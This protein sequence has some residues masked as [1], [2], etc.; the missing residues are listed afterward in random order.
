M[1]MKC[2]N[3][4]DSV[5]IATMIVSPPASSMPSLRNITLADIHKHFASGKL[6]SSQLV[7]AYLS[8]IAEVDHEFNSIIETNPDANDIARALDVE[9]A[10]GHRRSHLHGIP[11]LLK[12]NIPTLDK[13]ETTCGSLALV[14]ARPKQE[15]AVVAAL[16]NAGAVMLGKSNMAEWVGFRSTSGCSGWSARGGQTHGPF[17]KGSKASGSSSGSAVATVLGLCFAAI[18]TE[19][20]FSIVS[21]AEKSGVIGYKPTKDLIPSEGIIYASKKQD[22]VG[23]LTRTVKD[24]MLITHTLVVESD[25]LQSLPSGMTE[26][27]FLNRLYD[28]C[29]SRAKDLKSLRVGVPLDL[30]DSEDPPECKVEAFGRMLFRLEAKG[31]KVRTDVVVQ[32]WCEYAGLLQ[33]EAD[34][35][36]DTDMKSAINEY[37]A[38]LQTNP[39]NINNLQDLI[40]FTRDCP[41][42]QYS[43]R[44]VAGLERAEATNH[45]NDLYQKMMT[46]DQSFASCIEDALNQY[47]CDVLLIP[48]LSASLQTLAAKAGACVMSVPIGMYSEGTPVTVDPKNG[49]ITVAPGL[50]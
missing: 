13:T 41:E 9:L 43:A 4:A 46:K 23:V 1:L 6:T 2:C 48:A 15:A 14:G 5:E 25:S 33:K 37:F 35:V 49:L 20:C 19:T 47:D 26:E 10:E 29:D 38:N 30:I 7:R 34:I 28:S 36:L 21:P 39:R 3:E 40:D 44:N 32:G 50:P 11:I 27:A 24:A 18:G 16:R 31:A 12:D 17:V 42:E 22:T 45:M 8:R